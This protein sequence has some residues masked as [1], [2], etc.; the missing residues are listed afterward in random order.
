MN[1]ADLAPVAQ[2]AVKASIAVLLAALGEIVAERSGVLNLG[3]EGMMLLGALAGFAAG[4]ATGD[5]WLA[6]AAAGAAGTLA[7]LVHAA[8]AVGLCADQVLSGLALS[9]LGSGLTGFLGRPFLGRP[10]PVLPETAL[11]GLSTL[12][13]IGPVFFHQPPLAYLAY[14]LV[15]LVW[16]VLARTR[17]GLVIRACGEDAAAAHAS[18]APVRAVRV[19]CT[20][21]GGL[22]AGLAGAFLSLSYTP[23]WKEGM[24]QGQGWIAIAMV[25]FAGWRPLRAPLGAFLFGGLGALQFWFLAGG[26]VPVP[27]WVL[28][29]LPYLLT[30]AVL[31]LAHCSARLRLLAGAPGDLGRPFRREG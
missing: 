20:A 27:A 26:P 31:A 1:P 10:G 21:F 5:P 2:I 9:L 13:G 22:L 25:V 12:P 6:V 11:P 23:G 16:W 8:F 24:T 7:A 19:G 28:K 29:A 14:V 15:P 4:S 18:G 30:L 17:L 3:L